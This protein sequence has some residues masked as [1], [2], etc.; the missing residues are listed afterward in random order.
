MRLNCDTILSQATHL[1]LDS[2]LF[3]H[4]GYDSAPGRWTIHEDIRNDTG[5][6]DCDNCEYGV[7]DCAV[8][9]GEGEV[10][11]DICTKCVG[12]CLLNCPQ[13]DG[14]GQHD[15]DHGDPDAWYPMHTYGWP[16]PSS[17]VIPDDWR[18]K[19]CNMTVVTTDGGDF[20]VLTGGGMDFSWEIAATHINLGLAVPAVLAEL[21][22]MAGRGESE[23]DQRIIT[24][25]LK[26]LRVR[27]D[28]STRARDRLTEHYPQAA[29]KAEEDS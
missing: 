8:C 22:R 16:L 5:E 6:R 17:F 18:E 2:T 1:G 10:D 12:T 19:L 24:A 29:D 3:D 26:S 23:G 27:A 28:W 20:L 21:P 14:S 25:C 15:P 9:D 11:G 7:L 4:E 13:C